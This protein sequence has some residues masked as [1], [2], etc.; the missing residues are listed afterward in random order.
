MAC[1]IGH[2]Q[3][4]ERTHAA[5]QP[6]YLLQ[7]GQDRC[8]VRRVERLREGMPDF[9]NL[10]RSIANAVF[11]KD[12][13]NAVEQFQDSPARVIWPHRCDPNAESR[14]AR[15]PSRQELGGSIEEPLM[16]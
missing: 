5:I 15:D 2:E 4:I 13:T 10:L 12:R 6:L 9:G 8:C 7:H 14:H 16:S 3:I 11:S 1:A